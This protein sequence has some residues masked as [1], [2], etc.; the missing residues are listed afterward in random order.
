MVANRVPS[1]L[2]IRMVQSMQTVHHGSF[3]TGCRATDSTLK[4][5]QPY[6][7]RNGKEYTNNTVRTIYVD[8]YH[9][10]DQHY[11]CLS[12]PCLSHLGII[13]RKL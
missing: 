6:A 1:A 11:I 5:A 7:S 9:S 4:L 2:R 12:T 10:V 3:M 8:E 13:S